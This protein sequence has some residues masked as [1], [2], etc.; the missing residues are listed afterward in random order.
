MRGNPTVTPP[1]TTPSRSIPACAGEPDAAT[2]PP[3]STPVYPRVCGGTGC[4]VSAFSVLRGLSPRVRGNPIEINARLTAER[5]IPACAGEPR[6]RR[7]RPDYPWV[8][9]RVCGGTTSDKSYAVD[10]DG[11][12]PR[13]RG[14]LARILFFP[15]GLRSIPACAGEPN[16]HGLTAQCTAVYPRVCGGTPI[17]RLSVKRMQGLSPRVRGNLQRL[18]M[19]LLRLRSI[20]ACAGEPTRYCQRAEKDKV[21]PRVCGGTRVKMS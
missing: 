1:D 7:G 17:N 12:S 6:R 4:F 16:L 18:S 5:S 20:P 15:A 11:L 14:N 13:V 10:T 9:P 21:Y 8:Y 19:L 2:P 3:R